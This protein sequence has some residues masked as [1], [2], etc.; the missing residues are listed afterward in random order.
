MSYN[1]P[2]IKCF[3]CKKPGHKKYDCPEFQ[4]PRGGRGGYR[5]GGYNRYNRGYGNYRDNKCYNCGK[6]GHLSFEC[7][8]PNGK[9]CYICGKSGHL[10]KDCPESK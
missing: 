9:N 1:C 10:K 5:R 3:Y 2:E 8:K 6:F 7:D 4:K